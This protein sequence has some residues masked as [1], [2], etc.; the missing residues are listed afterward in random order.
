M[1][2]TPVRSMLDETETASGFRRRRSTSSTPSPR[3]GR[4]TMFGYPTLAVSLLL[5]TAPMFSQAAAED[6]NTFAQ[7]LLREAEALRQLV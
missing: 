6:E 3:E 2:R 1:R 4:S 7:A 5:V